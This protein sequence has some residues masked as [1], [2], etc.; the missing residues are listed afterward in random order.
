MGVLVGQDAE[1]EE[2]IEALEVMAMIG[3]MEG[4]EFATFVA[5]QTIFRPTV[6]KKVNKASLT[7]NSS[8]W[9]P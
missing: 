5:L 8:R 4:V 7:D 3:K 2:E 9:L 1:G 6:L